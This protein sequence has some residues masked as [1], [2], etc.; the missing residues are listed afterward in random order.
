LRVIRL[1]LGISVLAIGT[2][3]K[4]RSDSGPAFF[5]TPPPNLTYKTM[6]GTLT[7]Y[8]IG[9]KAGSV[10]IKASN[11]ATVNFLV[12]NTMSLNGANTHCIAPPNN[13]QSPPPELCPD[14]PAGGF[15]IGS[16]GITVYYWDTTFYATTAHVTNK[17]T[18]HDVGA[19]ARCQST[20][21]RVR[22]AMPCPMSGMLDRSRRAMASALRA[23]SISAATIASTAASCVIMASPNLPPRHRRF[24]SRC[25]SP[26]RG[27]PERRS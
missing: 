11:G 1:L 26:A 23:P 5:P 7:D 21:C 19:R 2:A 12:G 13:K 17:I 27:D 8:A 6:K 24:P 25:Y 22:C 15:N 10:V 3:S 18:S 16:S 20:P 14:W 4:A 9:M